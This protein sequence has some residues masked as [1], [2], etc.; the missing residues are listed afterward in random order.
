MSRLFSTRPLR[1][2]MALT[3]CLLIEKPTEWA[4]QRALFMVVKKRSHSEA[5][6]HSMHGLWFRH[7]STELGT[8]WQSIGSDPV[9]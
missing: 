4:L 5:A 9:V 8:C 2:G 3:V 6:L 1:V 7:S